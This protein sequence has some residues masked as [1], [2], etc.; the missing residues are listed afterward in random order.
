VQDIVVFAEVEEG[1]PL[2]LAVPEAGS[3]PVRVPDV[4]G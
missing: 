4:L 1:I 3:S 2:D